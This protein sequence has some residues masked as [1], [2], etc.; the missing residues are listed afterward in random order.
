MQRKVIKYNQFVA[1]MDIHYNV[2]WM[3]RKLKE[4]QAKRHP[5]DAEVLEALS[6]TPGTTSAGLAPSARS[7]DRL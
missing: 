2:P 7:D 4:L 1:N 5:V 3:S 6:P